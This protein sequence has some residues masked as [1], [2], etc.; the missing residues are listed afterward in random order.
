MLKLFITLVGLTVT[1]FSEKFLFPLD[2]YVVSCQTWSKNLERALPPPSYGHDYDT[3]PSRNSLAF[4]E[5]GL[6]DQTTNSSE[7]ANS[8]FSGILYPILDKMV[9]CY[10]NCSELLWEKNC[11]SDRE[12]ILKF[13]AEGKNFEITK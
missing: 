6:P 12:K 10:Q 8:E 7:M 4:M 2:T 5:L 11:S 3:L 1:L 9:F 13:E